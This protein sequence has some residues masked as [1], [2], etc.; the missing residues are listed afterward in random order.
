[1]PYCTIHQLQLIDRN[2]LLTKPCSPIGFISKDSTNKS[3]TDLSGCCAI[4]LH[5]ICYI[6]TRN[7]KYLYS[8]IINTKC[9]LRAICIQKLSEIQCIGK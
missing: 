4:V 6:K 1:M 3:Q 7:Q 9:L 2:Y 5:L 8:T